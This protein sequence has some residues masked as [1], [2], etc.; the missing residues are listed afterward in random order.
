MGRQWRRGPSFTSNYILKKKRIPRILLK[1]HLARN[2]KKC[3]EASS[4]SV[5]KFVQI[6][7]SGVEWTDLGGEGDN[8]YEG[9]NKEKSF[10]K[11]LIKNV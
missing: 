10:K 4:D 11:P 1:H 5:N 3:V 2:Y 9:I 7:A 8:L 6:M